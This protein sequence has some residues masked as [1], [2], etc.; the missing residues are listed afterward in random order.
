MA[1]TGLDAGCVPSCRSAERSGFGRRDG[2]AIALSRL[3]RDSS[4]MTLIWP[5]PPNGRQSAISP[6][7]GAPLSDLRRRDFVYF[8]ASL[9]SRYG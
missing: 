3:S 8:T 4:F 7:N 1:A 5:Q 9:F 2:V 6:G